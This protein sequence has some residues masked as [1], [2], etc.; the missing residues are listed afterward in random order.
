MDSDLKLSKREDGWYITNWP[1]P[2]FED[3]GPF[4]KAEAEEHR[5]ALTN[6]LKHWDDR[7]YWTSDRKSDETQEK[8]TK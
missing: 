6:T 5:R 8:K 4:D 2:G 7:R 3:C 1:G